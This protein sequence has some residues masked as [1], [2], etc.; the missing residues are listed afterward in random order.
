MRLIAEGKLER[1]VVWRWT[2]TVGQL[3][4]EFRPF[5]H[6]FACIFIVEASVALIFRAILKVPLCHRKRLFVRLRFH[7]AQFVDRLLLHARFSMSVMIV[8]PIIAVAGQIATHVLRHISVG[9]FADKTVSDCMKRA[10]S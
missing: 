5:P 4:P 3:S 10:A 2:R 1:S 9:K 8:H 7:L 6:E